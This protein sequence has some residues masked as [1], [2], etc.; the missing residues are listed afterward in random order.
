MI[1]FLFLFLLFAGIN[2]YFVSYSFV[3]VKGPGRKLSLPTDL[4]T[5]L[6][7]VGES[8]QF[9]LGFLSVINFLPLSHFWGFYV[10][11]V[12]F[13]VLF[14]YSQTFFFR[15]PRHS[16]LTCK[17]PSSFCL[18]SWPSSSFISRLCSL[19]ILQVFIKVI[20]SLCIFKPEGLSHVTMIG[21]SSEFH[22][23]SS[24]WQAC[25]GDWLARCCHDFDSSI[26]LW[27]SVLFSGTISTPD[28]ACSSMHL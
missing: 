17:Q 1:Y 23:L 13:K 9:P 21:P 11:F 24:I 22:D 2:W 5:D 16:L 3:S 8:Q 25:S 20:Y 27:N 12:P 26:S 14:F 15:F 6:G 28:N 10:A 7:T 19:Y 18:A 4:K